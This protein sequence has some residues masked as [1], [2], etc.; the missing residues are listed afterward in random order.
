VLLVPSA[1]GSAESCAHSA[2]SPGSEEKLIG[3]Y[4]PTKRFI[5][6][7]VD[8]VESVVRCERDHPGGVRAHDVVWPLLQDAVQ[9]HVLKFADHGLDVSQRG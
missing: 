9:N 6:P 5:H 3:K 8:V 4:T 1:T 2:R 7:N